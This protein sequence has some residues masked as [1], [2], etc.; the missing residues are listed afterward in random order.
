MVGVKSVTHTQCVGQGSGTPTKEGAVGEF[1]VATGGSEHEC[2]TCNMEKKNE[3]KHCV[4]P[5][6]F[7]R[8]Q[9]LAQWDALGFFNEDIHLKTPSGERLFL[10]ANRLQVVRVKGDLQPV[11]L[12][13]ERIHSESA[14]PQLARGAQ[15]P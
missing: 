2:C 1:V 14:H 6:P 10:D 5:A 9:A 4:D 13:Y 3:S 15:P 11:H 12:K 8:G 7:I